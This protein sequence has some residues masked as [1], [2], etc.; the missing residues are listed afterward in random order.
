MNC[1]FLLQDSARAVS[2]DSVSVWGVGSD[3]LVC[4]NKKIS[5]LALQLKPNA[6]ETKYVFKAVGGGHEFTDTIT[7]KYERQPWFQSMDCGC[8][9][10]STIDT[11]L[12]TGSIFKSATIVERKVDNKGNKNVIL[13]I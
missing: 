9:V 10:F 3:S 13:N 1:S 12:T 8:M 4:S 7:F 2:I 5:E 6:D 11:C